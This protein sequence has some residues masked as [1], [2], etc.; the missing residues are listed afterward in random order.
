[1]YT[2]CHTWQPSPRKDKL[3]ITLATLPQATEQQV[4]D[5]AVTHLLTQ[6]AQ[7]IVG[8]TCVYRGHRGAKCV[9]GCFIADDEYRSS[10]EEHDWVMLLERERVPKEHSGFIYDLQQIHDHCPVELWEEKLK[11]FA[12]KHSLKFNWK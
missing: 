12:E 11:E 4:F 5:Q 3:V 7:S 6:N 8:S 9:G 10:L 1:M 2:T